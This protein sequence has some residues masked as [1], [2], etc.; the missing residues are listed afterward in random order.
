M[1][2]IIKNDLGIVGGFQTFEVVDADTNEV[3]GYDQIVPE[4]SE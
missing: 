4:A 3:I 2:N 1:A